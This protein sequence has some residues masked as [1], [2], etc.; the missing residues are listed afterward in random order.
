MLIRA[1]GELVLTVSRSDQHN[2]TLYRLVHYLRGKSIRCCI[3][4]CT[5]T[6]KLPVHIGSVARCELSWAKIEG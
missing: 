6:S 4:Y 2:L 1:I 5:A 3:T